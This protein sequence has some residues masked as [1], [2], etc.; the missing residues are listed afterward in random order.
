MSTGVDADLSLEQIVARLP[1]DA[2]DAVLA[3]LDLEALPWD[4]SWTGRPS[5]ILPV[6]P[7]EGGNDWSTAL[8][9]G[10]RGSGKVEADRNGSAHLT[11]T[12]IG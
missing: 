8:F 12:G 11:R 9:L 2:Q 5:Q 3:G 4:W 10:G 6:L 7:E 1:P